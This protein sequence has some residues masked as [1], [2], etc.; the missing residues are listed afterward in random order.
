MVKLKFAQVADFC[1]IDYHV[2]DSSSECD[3]QVFASEHSTCTWHDHYGLRI[4]NDH[5]RTCY[6]IPYD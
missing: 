5:R 1:I 4:I 2:P 6:F 3:I